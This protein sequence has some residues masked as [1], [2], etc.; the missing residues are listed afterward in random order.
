VCTDVSSAP[1]T[2]DVAKKLGQSASSI[3]FAT[4]ILC[5]LVQAACLLYE[6][7]GYQVQ[8]S[9]NTNIGPAFLVGHVQYITILRNL[10]GLSAAPTSL[11][12]FVDPFSWATLDTGG[13]NINMVKGSISPADLCN[14]S[15]GNPLLERVVIFLSVIL[16]VMVVRLSTALIFSSSGKVP[17]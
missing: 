17:A 2:A 9:L 10:G 5:V 15:W 6:A 11:H 3:A 4:F 8:G 1:F 12:A 13:L 7:R 16:L 14:Q